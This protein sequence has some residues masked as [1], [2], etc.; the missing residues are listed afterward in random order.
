MKLD[1]VLRF[2]APGTELRK[3]EAHLGRRN[4]IGEGESSSS[5]QQTFTMS[6]EPGETIEAYGQAARAAGW[7]LVEEGCSRV[8]RTTTAEFRKSFAGFDATF[9]ISAHLD[10]PNA[11][12]HYVESGRRGLFVNLEAGLAQG[13]FDIGLHRNDVQCLRGIDLADPDLQAPKAPPSSPQALC[14]SVPLAAVQAIAPQVVRTVPQATGYGECWLDDGSSHPLFIV[15]QAGQPRAFYDDRL[16]PT[17][18]VRDGMFL[19][20]VYGR[21]APDRDRSVW[22]A[23]RTRPLLVS[24][25]SFAVPGGQE[26]EQLLFDLA[27]LLAQAEPAVTAP[28]PTSVAAPS[29]NDVLITYSLD[30]GIAGPMQLTLTRGGG[31]TYTGGAPHP[32]QFDVPKAT[33]DE[34]MAALARIEFAKLSRSYGSG[35]GPDSQVEVVTYQGRTVRI[36][37]NGPEELRPVTSILN[38]LL[39]EGRRRR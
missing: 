31:A 4:W 33:M 7:T 39:F 32:I 34:L 11:Q 28:A 19:F 15:A 29:A 3:Q 13:L 27:G 5:I 6:A 16:L 9:S 26:G 24:S 37:S 8:N 23:T 14:S 12:G 1:P 30:G 21:S 35:S 18:P 22:V 38:G 20:S 25:T 36:R 10:V 17:T 2:R